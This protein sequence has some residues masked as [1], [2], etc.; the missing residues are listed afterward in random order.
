MKPRSSSTARIA[1]A[2]ALALALVLAIVVI[3]GAVGGG[4]SGSGNGHRGGSSAHKAAKKETRHVPAS[5]EVQSGDTLISIAHR[6]GVTVREI[7]ALNPQVDPQ[8]LI[9]G[10]EL[11]LR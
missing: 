1:A 7:E 8:I 4:S 3:G 6:T 9:A 10:E 11:K 2:S 5:Y